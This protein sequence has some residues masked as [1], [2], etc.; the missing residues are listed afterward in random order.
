MN[1]VQH[2]LTVPK[3]FSSSRFLRA[4]GIALLALFFFVPGASAQCGSYSGPAFPTTSWCSPGWGWSWYDPFPW[5]WGYPYVYPY[6]PYS[7][8]IR[9]KHVAKDVTVYVDGAYAGTAGQLKKFRLLPGKHDI[10]LRDSSAHTLRK[11]SVHVLPGK[12]VEILGD[13]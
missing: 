2:D 5:G 3:R 6:E 9:I 8:V 11:E 4:C 10:E 7:G 12:T 1:S 13:Q